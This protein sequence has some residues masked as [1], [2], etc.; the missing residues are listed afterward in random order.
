MARKSKKSKR[1]RIAHELS[2][3]RRKVIEKALAEHKSEDRTEWDR[4]AEWADYK[5]YLL[6]Y[7]Q[8]AFSMTFLRRFDSS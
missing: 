3:R 1:V 5:F 2:K 7:A 4:N 6:I 8:R